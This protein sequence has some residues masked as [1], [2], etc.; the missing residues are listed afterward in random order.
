[1][2][3]NRREG[4]FPKGSGMDDRFWGVG[5]FTILI[6]VK[7]HGCVHMSKLIQLYTKYAPYGVLQLYLNKVGKK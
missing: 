1:M 5:T 6:V 3:E 2:V 4:Q 7:F